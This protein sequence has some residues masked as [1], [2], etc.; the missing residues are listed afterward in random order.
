MP[1]QPLTRPSV[2]AASGLI[3]GFAAARYTGRR[4]LGGVLFAAAGIW[5]ARDW[6]RTSGPA[7]ATGL[8][9]V[10]AGAMG[11]SHPLAKRLGPWR[12]VLAVTALVVAAS[13][14]ASR[15]AIR[16]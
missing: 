6:S 14:V 2:V 8:G 4:E 11:G 3:G 1:A 5:C 9:A 15:R 7:I 13:E 16:R 12:S 10:Y